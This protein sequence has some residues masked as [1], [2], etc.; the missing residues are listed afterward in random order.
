[1]AAWSQYR[2]IA[3][4]SGQYDVAELFAAFNDHFG[5]LSKLSKNFDW[6]TVVRY[7]CA[8]RRPQSREAGPRFEEWGRFGIEEFRILAKVL[9]SR[10][11][12]G[13]GRANY[14]KREGG[15]RRAR[16]GRKRASAKRVRIL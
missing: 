1:M 16:S 11:I 2:G 6:D 4:L 10:R 12:T 3:A 7:H 14:R 5:R 8:W 9:K 13:K 15:L